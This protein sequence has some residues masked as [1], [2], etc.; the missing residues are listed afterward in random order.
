MHEISK[1]FMENKKNVSKCHL[2]KFLSRMISICFQELWLLCFTPRSA[3]TLYYC[4][5][6]IIAID[7]GSSQKIISAF[8][9]PK[10]MLCRQF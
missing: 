3:D 6:L 10:H 1:V 9:A 4:T 2:L 5:G 8:I 7:E